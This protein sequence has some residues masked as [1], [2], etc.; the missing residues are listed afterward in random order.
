MSLIFE[1][2]DIFQ[3]YFAYNYIQLNKQKF[4]KIFTDYNKIALFVRILSNF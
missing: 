1:I 3:K 2:R 4:A